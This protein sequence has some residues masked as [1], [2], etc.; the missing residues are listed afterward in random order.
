MELT[1]VWWHIFLYPLSHLFGL[2]LLFLNSGI[3]S[4]WIIMTHF[5]HEN[6]SI[7]VWWLAE[8]GYDCEYSSQCLLLRVCGPFTGAFNF[9]L[10]FFHIGHFSSFYSTVKKFCFILVFLSMFKLVLSSQCNFDLFNFFSECSQWVHCFF[11]FLVFVFRHLR[12]EMSI[13]W[14]S[15]PCSYWCVPGFY[16]YLRYFASHVCLCAATL[17]D[18]GSQILE[19][20]SVLLFAIVC[21]IS[22]SRTPSSV[23]DGKCSLF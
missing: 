19:F 7:L 23:G 14:P 10:I 18:G 16:P 17:W 3:F 2:F 21:E 5:S 8:L 20:V 11:Q 4:D 9:I 15:S 1:Q 22:D 6:L 12:L 13:F